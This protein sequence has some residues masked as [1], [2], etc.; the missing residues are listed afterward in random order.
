MS[1]TDLLWEGRSHAKRGPKPALSIEQIA[2]AG[3]AIADDEGLDAVSMQRVA[4]ELDFTKMSLYRYVASKAELVSVMIEFA[5]GEPPDL[6][7]VRGGWRRRVETWATHLSATWQSHPWLPYAT[8]GDRAMG[9]REVDWVECALLPL[10]ETRLHHAEQ[11][12]TV[13]LLFG[14]LRNTQSTR[15]AGTQPWTDPTQVALLQKHADRFPSLATVV[16]ARLKRP[17][18]NGRAFGLTRLLD[19]IEALHQSRA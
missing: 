1:T 16:T 9:P 11:L 15:P 18:D 2:S 17:A 13:L 10:T 19:G 3:V 14:H 6:S 12:D 5:V 8:I 4:D 7:N